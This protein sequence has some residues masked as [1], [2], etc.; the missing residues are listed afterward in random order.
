MQ[1]TPLPSPVDPAA[2]AEARAASI[3]APD[4][5]RLADLLG[6]VADPVR[7][8][9]LMALGSVD[10]LCVGDLALVLGVSE[11]AV[12]YALKLLRTAG[13]VS[14]ERDGRVLR[15]RL[16]DGFPHQLVE[17]C[18]RQLLTITDSRAGPR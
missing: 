2:V 11:D 13:L 16:A 10:T 6:L 12:S 9:V 8:R 17:H 4:A 15:Y 5:R 1:T 7:S 14:F 3:S 18:L